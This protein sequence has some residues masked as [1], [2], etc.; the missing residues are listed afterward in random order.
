M[1]DDNNNNNDNSAEKATSTSEMT[2]T[3]NTGNDISNEEVSLILPVIPTLCDLNSVLASQY[4][5]L[6]D[7]A[8]STKTRT[9]LC[10]KVKV[11]KKDC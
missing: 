6:K 9:G 1:S 4:S 11:F 3:S 8:S 2:Q 7:G 10:C 5:F